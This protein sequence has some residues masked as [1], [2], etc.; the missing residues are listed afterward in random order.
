MSYGDAFLS[1]FLSQYF[2]YLKYDLL[3]QFTAADPL[4]PFI[5]DNGEGRR[6]GT[7]VESQSN[8]LRVIILTTAYFL[9]QAL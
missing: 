7:I 8:I 1:F 3:D 4:L 5:K 9:F 2:P 6:I